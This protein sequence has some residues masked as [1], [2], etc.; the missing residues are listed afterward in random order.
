MSTNKEKKVIYNDNDRAIVAALSASDRAL[1][2][3]ELSEATGLNLKPGN[4]TA[5]RNKLLVIVA[6]EV[7]PE[8]MGKRLVS[9]YTLISK[10]V[11]S[12]KNGKPYGYSETETA[13]MNALDGAESPMTL[14]EISEKIGAPLTSGNINALVRNK[15]NVAMAG[16]IEVIVK[17]KPSP[18]KTYTVAEQLPE[19]FQ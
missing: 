1:T 10:D 5:A 8:R 4:I 7:E 12:D 3:A 9:T 18:V 11:N 16:K 17:V 13:I 2:L 19:D 15:G 6:G 14:A